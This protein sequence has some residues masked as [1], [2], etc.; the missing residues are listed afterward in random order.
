VRLGV[1][2]N[3]LSPEA[4]LEVSM[5]AVHFSLLQALSDAAPRQG[6]IEAQQFGRTIGRNA[7]DHHGYLC[8]NL[9]LATHATAPQVRNFESETHFTQAF[10]SG[11]HELSPLSS[12]RD[13]I[14]FLSPFIIHAIH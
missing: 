8:L 4:E 9:T 3:P 1:R 2:V 6:P 10:H 12:I 14:K 11:M 7:H 13:E 5:V